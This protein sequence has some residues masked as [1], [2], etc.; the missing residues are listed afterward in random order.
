MF[1]LTQNGTPV[2]ITEELPYTGT[3][4]LKDF[5]GVKYDAVIG[6]QELHD[7]TWA[8]VVDLAAWVT[9]I[10][11]VQH[12]AC[13]YENCSQR[14]AIVRIPQVGDEVSYGF[15]GDYYP[16]GKIGRV[17][18]KLTV[19][20]VD[21]NGKELH[22]YNRRRETGSWIMSGGTWSLV[23]GHRNEKNPSF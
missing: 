3:A 11:V 13:S 5:P 8:R 20:T 19:V 6:P 9:A 18:P 7:F 14:H 15:N 1:I 12:V 10:T 17:T 16:D 23:M 2:A 4:K 22:R 21:E